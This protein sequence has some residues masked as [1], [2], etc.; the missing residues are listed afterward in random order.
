M[1][2]L[3]QET[4]PE[5][6]GLDAPALERLDRHFARLVDAGKLAGFLVA[7]ARG[8]RVA[9]LTAYGARDVAAGLPVESD[10][11]WRIY[12][13]T[14]PVTAVGA[15]M[16]VEEGLLALDDPVG[17]HLPAFAEPRVYAGGSGDRVRTRPA[18]GPLLVRHLMTHTAGLTFAFYHAHPVDAL[19]RAA[20]LE[21]SVAPGADLAGTTEVYA[22]L[23][24]QF[25]PGTQ[26]N[27]S[28]ASNVLGRII[29]VASG[30]PLDVYLAERV[31]RPLGMT[32]AGFQVSDEQAGRLAEL[33]GES[34]T[35]GIRPIDGLP[36]R[37]RPRFLS[38]SGGMVASAHD[39][40]RFMELLRRRGEL[41]GT[42]LLT[43]A[44]VG[45]MTRN[46]LPGGADL[47]SFGSRPAHDEPGNEGV[48]FGLGVSVVVDPARTQSPS[49]LGSYGWSGV[50]T[51]TFW[52]DPGRD[53]TVQFHTQV[54]PRSSHTVFRDLKR[55][56]HEAV[57]H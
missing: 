42:R 45:L 50:A 30:R 14:K 13:M 31:F 49:A 22:S 26:W 2:V 51:T 35:G 53:L 28:V 25:D 56:V 15:L 5:E 20:G 11:L 6:A 43:P 46:H 37:G 57:A 44:T 29:E 8:G 47:R 3:R 27:Y 12:S 55:L 19:Y 40:H 18:A 16:L 10:T 23:P 7:L 36:L 21:S 34:D 9:H 17:R 39:W 33:Y 48:G 52:V 38:G 54:R 1:G 41:H 4:G 24:L 32:D